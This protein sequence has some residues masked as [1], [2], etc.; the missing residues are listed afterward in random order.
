MELRLPGLSGKCLHPHPARNPTGPLPFSKTSTF[1]VSVK[2]DGNVTLTLALYKGPL[3]PSCTSTQLDVGQVRNCVISGLWSDRYNHRFDT[4][5]K[6]INMLSYWFFRLASLISVEFPVPMVLWGH[7]CHNLLVHG[8]Q[9]R[10][11]FTSPHRRPLAVGLT[12]NC[13]IQCPL[14]HVS[15]CVCLA[16]LV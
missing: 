9:S 16:S 11:V 14:C 13:N 6:S 10:W 12:I 3:F 2:P 15:Y 4:P 1:P 8:L 7:F 5:I